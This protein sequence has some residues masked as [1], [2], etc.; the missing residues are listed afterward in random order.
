MIG[1]PFTVQD[2]ADLVMLD[3]P[4]RQIICGSLSLAA[5]ENL[6]DQFLSVIPEELIRSVRRLRGDNRVELLNRTS[7]V[8][9]D[10]NIEPARFYDKLIRF[11]ADTLI[12]NSIIRWEIPSILNELSPG[13]QVFNTPET[14]PFEAIT[15]ALNPSNTEH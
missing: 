13:A 6:M 7:I 9:W 15:T 11:R 1:Q 3:V 4:R 14:N 8:P 12:V 10:L 5:A 2:F